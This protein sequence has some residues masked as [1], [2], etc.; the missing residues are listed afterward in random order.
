[1]SEPMTHA[2]VTARIAALTALLNMN[3][4]KG[5]VSDTTID[6]EATDQLR[7]LLIAE[8]ENPT[9]GALR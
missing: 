2:E 3:R 6:Y 9:R 1:M 7:R 5:T 4:A 8:R